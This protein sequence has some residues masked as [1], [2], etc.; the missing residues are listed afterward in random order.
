MQDE[1]RAINL[2]KRSAEKGDL[3]GKLLYVEL[4]LSDPHKY[5]SE[6]ELMEINRYC[7]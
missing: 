4:V 7:R 6:E 1:N 5:N 2:I 3:Q